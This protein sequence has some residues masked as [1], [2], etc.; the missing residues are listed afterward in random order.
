MNWATCLGFDPAVNLLQVIAQTIYW[1]HPLVW[2]A[3]RCIRAEREKCCDEMAI[4]WIGTKAGDFSTA[5]VNMLTTEHESTRPIPSLAVSGPVKSI[6]DRIKTVMNPDKEFY[7]RPSTIAQVAI[8][9]LGI[10]TVPTSLVLMSPLTGMTAEKEVSMAKQQD[11]TEEVTAVL[12]GFRKAFKEQDVDKIMAAYSDDYS[13]P[14]GTDK[15]GL[16][17]FLEGLAEQGALQNTTVGIEEC[18]IVVQEDSATAGPV[19]HSSPNSE[20]QHQYKLKREKRTVPGVL[21]AMGRYSEQQQGTFS[22]PK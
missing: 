1:F 9:L 20:T 21:S 8:L 12:A 17:G 14:K 16:R 15:S 19:T 4:A 3:N 18:E 2:W 10:I 5:V 7:R 22:R 6:E 11:S 13:D